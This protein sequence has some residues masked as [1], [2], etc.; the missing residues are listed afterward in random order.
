MFI[1][2]HQKLGWRYWML[3]VVALMV[4]IIG[5]PVGIQVAI[6][7]TVVHLVHFVVRERSLR[8]FPVQVRVAVLFFML[9]GTLEPFQ[10]VYWLLAAGGAA[11]V[12]FGYCLMARAVSLMPWNLMVWISDGKQPFTLRH[13]YATFFSRPLVGNVL[14]GFAEET[15]ASN[16]DRSVQGPEASVSAA[17]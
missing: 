10:F 16:S 11:K 15:A 12:L 1:I 9:L 6:G 17:L 7:V 13:I 8:S 2:Q 14:Q 4:G 5:P 3:T